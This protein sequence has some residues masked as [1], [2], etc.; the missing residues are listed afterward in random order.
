MEQHKCIQDERIRN[1]ETGQAEMR[2]YVRDIREDIQEIKT[3]LKDYRP[4]PQSNGN[5]SESSKVWQPIMIELI[6][7]LGLCITIL[8]AIV[9]A[10]KILGK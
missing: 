7:L 3:S 4:P 1:L 6:K 10:I 2:V 8:G 9:G 5:G